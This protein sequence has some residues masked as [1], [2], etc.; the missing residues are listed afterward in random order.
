LRWGEIDLGKTAKGRNKSAEGHPKKKRGAG[1]RERWRTKSC[2]FFTS[3]IVKKKSRDKR[4]QPQTTTKKKRGGRGKEIAM[5]GK[6]PGENTKKQNIPVPKGTVKRN[7]IRPV[8]NGD[9]MTS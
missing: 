3:R 7:L 8:T 4:Q 6:A 5:E 2:Y 1:R 9:G